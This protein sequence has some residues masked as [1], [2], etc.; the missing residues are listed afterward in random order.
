[1]LIDGGVDSLARGDEHE[2]GTIIEDSI[3]LAALNELDDLAVRIIACIGLGAEQSITY[4]HIFENIA[5][6]TAQAGFLGACAL[7]R[8]MAAYQAY[9]SAVAWVH[10]QP[11]QDPSVINASVV[12]AVQGHFGDYHLTEKTRGSRLW[13][14]PLMALYWFFDL[15]TVAQHN[16]LLA[17]L[18]TTTTPGE[19]VQATF[20]LR[21]RV[22]PRMATRVPL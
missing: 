1:M 7:T 12:S 3:S 4:A 21:R 17:A 2:M 13:I 14:S 10:A 6:L 19:A 20:A 11:Y 22:R 8:S 15:L 5:T 18:L 16:L 9:E